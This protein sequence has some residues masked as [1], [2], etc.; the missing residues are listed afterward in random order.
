MGGETSGVQLVVEG[1]AGEAYFTKKSNDT[2]ANF[3]I[4][5]CNGKPLLNISYFENPMV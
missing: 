5:D 2:K 4:E 3:C 1:A